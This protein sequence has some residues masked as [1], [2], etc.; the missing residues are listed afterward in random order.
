MALSNLPGCNL[1][2]VHG[3]ADTLFYCRLREDCCAFEDA[4]NLNRIQVV[5]PG[6][7]LEGCA[8]RIKV[9]QILPERSPRPVRSV[10]RTEHLPYEPMLLLVPLA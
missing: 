10:A 7:S 2:H 3:E 5:G 4:W 9:R 1:R 8:Y 6:N